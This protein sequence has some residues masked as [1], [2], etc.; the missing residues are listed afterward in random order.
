[1]AQD[2]HITDQCFLDLLDFAAMKPFE[3]RI[4]T[5]T[6][7]KY[8]RATYEWQRIRRL[9]KKCADAGVKMRALRYGGRMSNLTYFA[10]DNRWEVR[11]A[12]K[13]ADFNKEWRGMVAETLRLA[14]AYQ[15]F[16]S[17]GRAY[18]ET[19]SLLKPA[20]YKG[21]RDSPQTDE[22]P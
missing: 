9:A 1:M 8:S 16:A 18:K 12:S 14:L 5:P 7:R 20:F 21:F 17:H 3:K 4:V 19:K 22:T 6:S 11:N 10:S 15:L 13:V 2:L